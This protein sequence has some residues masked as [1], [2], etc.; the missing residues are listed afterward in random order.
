MGRIKTSDKS[1]YR[2]EMDA[3]I[4]FKTGLT[5]T[6][7]KA[8]QLCATHDDHK[9]A[10]A[11]GVH[12]NTIKS[13]RKKYVAFRNVEETYKPIE[14][15]PIVLTSLTELNQDQLDNRF[16]Q[17]IIPAIETLH[18]VLI[19]PEAN[20]TAK[21]NASKFIISK[22]YEQVNSKVAGGSQS[23]SDLREALKL[24]VNNDKEQSS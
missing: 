6:Q 9:V 23:I 18:N 5:L 10:K 4:D 24:V 19:D 12:Y 21:V 13:W 7:L 11:I 16:G 15:K 1:S 17:L 14:Q 8:A 22:A 20:A 3:K 2:Q